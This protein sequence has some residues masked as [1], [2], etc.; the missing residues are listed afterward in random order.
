M[1]NRGADHGLPVSQSLLSED[2]IISDA[3]TPIQTGNEQGGSRCPDAHG[4]LWPGFPGIS[5]K[6]AI[7]SVL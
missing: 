5:F 2:L 7:K 3:I 4:S 6:E 1:R